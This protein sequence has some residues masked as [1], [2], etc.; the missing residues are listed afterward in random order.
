MELSISIVLY[1]KY[2]DTQIYRHILPMYTR[3]W[4]MHTTLPVAKLFNCIRFT[5][6]VLV[7]ALATDQMNK[8]KIEAGTKNRNTSCHIFIYLHTVRRSSIIL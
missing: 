8:S 5:T 1:A 2:T 7:L 6:L 4:F 3:Y